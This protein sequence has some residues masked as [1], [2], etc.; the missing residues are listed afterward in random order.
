MIKYE[1]VWFRQDD[2]VEHEKE[3]DAVFEDA[4]EALLYCKVQNESS[5]GNNEHYYV[6][7]H[8]D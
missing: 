1:V 3:V 5:N 4:L 7:V 8:D 2:Y 6:E